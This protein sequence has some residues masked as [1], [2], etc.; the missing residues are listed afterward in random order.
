[1][2]GKNKNHKLIMYF[3]ILVSYVQVL[4]EN[5]LY[6]NGRSLGINYFLCSKDHI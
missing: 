2:N 5:E 4:A 3:T 1:M 6:I